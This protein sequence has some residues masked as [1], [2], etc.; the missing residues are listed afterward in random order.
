[1]VIF[2]VYLENIVK[3]EMVT[4]Y[5]INVTLS[6][7]KRCISAPSIRPFLLRKLRIVWLLSNP[8]NFC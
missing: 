3:L 4:Q 5:T 2:L 7:L 1:M 6:W 8:Q